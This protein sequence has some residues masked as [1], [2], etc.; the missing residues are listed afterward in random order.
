MYLTNC[1]DLGTRFYSAFRVRLEKEMEHISNTDT[2]YDER[3]KIMNASNP[4]Y[5]LRNYIAQKAIEAAENGDF[6]EVNSF[7]HI[8]ILFSFPTHLIAGILGD[9]SVVKTKQQ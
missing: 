4:K 2:W 7:S 8:Y 9:V 5:I 1:I 3:L 6:L